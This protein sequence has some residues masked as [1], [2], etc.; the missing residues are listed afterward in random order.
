MPTENFAALRVLCTQTWNRVRMKKKK[1]IRNPIWNGLCN[2]KTKWGNTFF[3][4]V[5]DLSFKTNFFLALGRYAENFF[6]CSLDGHASETKRIDYQGLLSHSCLILRVPAAEY[7]Q[8]AHNIM[9]LS[10]TL[11]LFSFLL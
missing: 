6:S 7:I 11:L 8:C 4:C 2:N 1:C 9:L 3:L 5:C 10:N